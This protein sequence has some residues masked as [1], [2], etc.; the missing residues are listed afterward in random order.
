MSLPEIDEIPTG[1]VPVPDVV[2]RLAGD[3][4]ITPVWRNELGGLTFRLDDGRG[5]VRYAKWIATGTP[6]IDLLAE[7][8]RLT[9]ARRWVNV[10]PVLEQGSDADG[11]WLVTTALPGRSAVDDHW[12]ATPEVSAKA[13]RAIGRGLRVLHDALP[14]EECPFDWSVERRL[15]RA[16]ERI[17]D[18]EG[19]KNWSPEHRHLDLARARATIGDPPPIDRLVVCHGDACAPNTLVNDDG[20]FAA[21]VDL[22]SLGVADRWADLAVAAWS[23]EWNHGPGY[24]HLVYEAYGVAPDRER[25]AYYRLLWDMA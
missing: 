6:E 23:T 4:D 9:W 7:A 13:A 10:P 15:V 22:G 24:D 11:S 16:D 25:I 1:P 2:A 19:P 18:G 17:A 3:D 14:V 12:R 8:E 20:T 21:H 5:G